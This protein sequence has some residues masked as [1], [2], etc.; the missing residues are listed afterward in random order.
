MTPVIYSD[1]FNSERYVP[2]GTN[3]LHSVMSLSQLS[4]KGD[5]PPNEL[6]LWHSH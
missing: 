5:N 4:R 6:V 1:N 2:Q 3:N